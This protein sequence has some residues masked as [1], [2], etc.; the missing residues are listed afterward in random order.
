V[1]ASCERVVR[2]P[3]GLNLHARPA[4]AFTRTAMRFGARITVAANGR[5]ADAKSVLGVMGLG[6]KGGTALWIR[7]E[8][9]DAVAAVEALVAC[10]DGRQ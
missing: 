5:E 4:G 10:L 2:L 7:A 6:A 9:D 3:E 8:G 1:P